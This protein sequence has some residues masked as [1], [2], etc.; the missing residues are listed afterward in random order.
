MSRE[1]QIGFPCPHLVVEEP[2]SI[3]EDRRSLVTKAPISNSNSVRILVNNSLYVPPSGLESQAELFSGKG[4]FRIRPC[5][6]LSGPDANVF[7]VTTSAGSLTV[8][9]PVGDFVNATRIVEF[10]R[11][12]G[13][14]S[15]ALV[16]AKGQ[17][18][19]IIDS[20][21]SGRKSFVRVSGG[22][23]EAL[24]YGQKSARGRVIYPP[25]V[26][27][28][29]EEVYPASG[30][31][32]VVLVPARYPKFI[33]PVVGNPDFKVTYGSMPERC[34]RCQA[35]YVENDYRFDI[36]GGLVTIVNEDLLYQACLKILLTSRGSNPYHVGYGSNII[37][38]IGSKVTLSTAASLRE[39]VINALNSMQSLQSG[40]R[41]YQQVSDKERLYRIL[42]VDVNPGEDPTTF[43]ISVVVSNGTG[44]PVSVNIT[45][46]APGAVALA[47]S[48]GQ[49]LG[50]QPTRVIL[51]EQ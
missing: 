15:I 1:I 2:V 47:G 7:S 41:R 13:A 48:N 20:Q 3:G 30:S 35:Y 22:A 31:S 27:E 11:S 36:S 9:L 24:G 23:V 17:N 44:Q 33:R 32:R 10:L 12:S 16:E 34:P 49:S 4:P 29:R 8:S 28:A 25:W 6:G 37:N 51:G 50:E 18:V 45:Y 42:N 14:D 46:T 38:R 39:D 43:L 26:L 19:S 5:F 40:Q 21:S